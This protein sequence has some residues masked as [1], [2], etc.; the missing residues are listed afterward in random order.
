MADMK[1]LCLVIV[2]AAAALTPA[3]S[4]KDGGQPFAGRWD[5]TV[6]TPKGTYPSWM[7]FSEN[8]GSSQVR[9]VGRVASVH[10]ATE[11]KLEGT[12]LTFSTMEWFEKEIP[13]TWEM[14]IAGGK[15]TGHQKRSDGVEGQL[16]GVHAPALQRKPPASW[17]K[18]E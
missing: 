13:V 12:H 10:P 17:G 16:A 11:V 7:E 9:V 5:L 8:G 6:T 14:N 1:S 2:I 15:I 18:P 4:K 3:L